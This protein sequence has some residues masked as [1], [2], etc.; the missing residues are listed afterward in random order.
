VYLLLSRFVWT[1]QDVVLNFTISAPGA[2]VEDVQAA[3]A[4][5]AIASG[6]MNSDGSEFIE[7]FTITE[8]EFD[9]DEEDDDDDDDDEEEDDDD[10]EDDDDEEDDD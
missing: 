8:V 5:G 1:R 10:D 4:D 7:H 3:L 9:D 2:T 6:L